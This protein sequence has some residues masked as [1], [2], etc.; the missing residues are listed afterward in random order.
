MS[1]FEEFASTARDLEHA[2]EVSGVAL[3]IDWDDAAAVRALAAESLRAGP[4]DVE[5]LLHSQDPGAR[6]KG[7]IF[8]LATLML[9][10]MTTSAN[11]GVH[12]HGGHAWKAFG[13]ALFAVTGSETP[14]PPE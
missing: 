12:T 4:A 8:A 11:I 3:G 1:G 2:L 6:A 14:T 9:K 10:L 13:Q 5:R 7:K